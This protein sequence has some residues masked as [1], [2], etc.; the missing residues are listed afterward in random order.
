MSLLKIEAIG[1]LGK[2]AVIGNANGKSVIN[3][4]I[5][6]T[7]KWQAA[8]G[9]KERT[10]WV[11]CAYWTDKTSVAQFLV[12]GKEVYIEG[13]PEIR[14]YP[15][16]DGTTGVSLVCRVFKLLL[17]GGSGGQQAAAPRVGGEYQSG[18]A[19]APAAAKAGEYKPGAA[20]DL[21]EAIDDLPF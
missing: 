1:N 16:N 17:V 13:T 12:K 7:E 4:S 14:V 10:T 2:D 18:A 8:D 20:S 11:E 15:K 19:A 9:P 5:A 21:T 6:H 3:F